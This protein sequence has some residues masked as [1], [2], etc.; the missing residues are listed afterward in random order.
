MLSPEADE[1]AARV[2]GG[3]ALHRAGH[4]LLALAVARPGRCR[5]RSRPTRGSVIGLVVVGGGWVRKRRSYRRWW[6]AAARSGRRRPPSSWSAPSAH[7]R[8]STVMRYVYSVSGAR[9][10]TTT[11]LTSSLRRRGDHLP[12]PV[13]HLDGGPTVGGGRW[14][15]CCRPCRGA[16]RRGR[17][18]RPPASDR[19]TSC[20]KKPPQPISAASVV[21]STR[22]TKGSKRR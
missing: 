10:S 7:G 8:P 14:H 16:G 21:T 18:R 11:W 13:A 9:P 2:G 19:S 12:R 4:S 6:S 3:E 1:G 22:W 5:P 20:W 15:R 17:R